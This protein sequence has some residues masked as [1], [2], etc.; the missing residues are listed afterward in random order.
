MKARALSAQRLGLGALV[1]ILLSAGAALGATCD[2]GSVCGAPFTCPT[3]FS[4]PCCTISADVQ[5]TDTCILDFVDVGIQTVTISATGALRARTT[6]ARIHAANLVVRGLLQA[7]GGDGLTYPTLQV[8]V[9]DRIEVQSGGRVDVAAED[10]AQ[11]GSVRITAGGR[12]NLSGCDVSADGGAAGAGGDIAISSTGAALQVEDCPLHADGARSG[13][14]GGSITLTA[15]AQVLINGPLTANGGVPVDGSRSVADTA[16]IAVEAAGLVQVTHSIQAHGTRSNAG[17]SIKL[18]STGDQVQISGTSGDE[19]DVDSAGSL[20]YRCVGGTHSGE[21]CDQYSP[22]CVG[23]NGECLFR[24]PQAGTIT[25]DAATA[26]TISGQT[27]VHAKGTGGGNGG[28]VS[29]L[30]RGGNALVNAPLSAAATGS[31]G[32]GGGIDVNAA[33]DITVGATLDAHGARSGI[34]GAVRLFAGGNADITGDLIATAAAGQYGD[35]GG[36]IQ[37]AAGPNGTI[38]ISGTLDA[39]AQPVTGGGAVDG[40]IVVGPACDV[41]LS[42]S[43]RTDGASGGSNIVKY[44]NSFDVRGGTMRADSDRS[45]APA[46]QAGNLIECGCPDTSPA[47][48]V[49]DGPPSCATSPLVSSGTSIIPGEQDRP[50]P[51]GPCGC[52]DG[53]QDLAATPP[54]LCDENR[55]VGG[56]SAG[57]PCTSDAGC[58]GGQCRQG[59]GSLACVGGPRSGLQCSRDDDCVLAM[60]DSGPNH[61]TPCSTSVD[62]LGDSCLRGTCSGG[63]ANGQPCSAGY[64]CFGGHCTVATC[65][66]VNGATCGASCA[67]FTCGDGVRSAGEECD[68]GNGSDGD[69]CSA[70]C[71]T[72]TP[73]WQCNDTDIC[74]ESLNLWFALPCTREPSACSPICHDGHVTPPEECDDGNNDSFDGCS[75]SCQIEA[76]YNCP[77][78]PSVCTPQPSVC[79]NHVIEPPESCDDGRRNDDSGHCKTNCTLNINGDGHV[80]TDVEQCDNGGRCVGGSSAG[81][82]C[83]VIS[84]IDRLTTQCPGGECRPGDGALECVCRDCPGH[85]GQSCTQDADCGPSREICQPVLNAQCDPNGQPAGCGNG[86]LA[87]GEDCDDGIDCSHGHQCNGAHRPCGFYCT[88]NQCGDWDVNCGP[89]GVCGT[90][91]DVEECDEGGQNGTP[92]SRCDSLCRLNCG[93]GNLDPGEQCD[94]GR[95]SNGDTN[96]CTSEC[97]FNVCGD[98]KPSSTDPPPFVTPIVYAPSAVPFHWIDISGSSTPAPL[99]DD[100]VSGPIDIGFDVLFFG[101]VFSQVY[102]SSNGFIAFDPPTSSGCCQGLPLPSSNGPGGNLV[103]GF[104]TDLY[105]P[106]GAGTSY[107]QV[108]DV[109]VIQ[110]DAPLFSSLFTGSGAAASFQ[111]Q[112]HKDSDRIEIHYLNAQPDHQTVTAGVQNGDG[113]DGFQH[114]S[115]FLGDLFQTAVAY[116]HVTIGRE[117]CDDGGV[118]AVGHTCN[119]D[120]RKCK[121]NCTRNPDYKPVSPC[122]KRLAAWYVQSPVPTVGRMV[123]QDGAAWCD[124]DHSVDGECVFSVNLCALSQAFDP[125]EPQSISRVTLTG[126][127]TTTCWGAAAAQ[128]L[129]GAVSSLDSHAS[130]NG[131]C[132]NHS[133]APRTCD[134]MHG[135]N[136]GCDARHPGDGICSP[137]VV[138]ND[139]LVASAGAGSDPVCANGS[140]SALQQIKVPAGRKLRVRSMAY[141]VTRRPATQPGAGPVDSFAL[142]HD[143]L[144]LVCH[145]AGAAPPPTWTEGP[146]PATPMVTPTPAATP[147]STATESATATPSSTDTAAATPTQT[148]TATATATQTETAAATATQTDTASATSTSTHTATATI[149]STPTLTATSSRRPTRTPGGES[150]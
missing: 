34:G 146:C 117:E 73:I 148:V 89:D 70:S 126:L 50:R 119:G 22:Q 21:L 7:P 14:P 82:A 35:S 25:V 109:F 76:G 91:D 105:P 86:Y 128:T 37:V 63:F 48:G 75:S 116:D 1:V 16:A 147:S 138:F 111:Y 53:S 69:G 104:W 47:D 84:A 99:G 129:A 29:L 122:K 87:P 79:G 62:C 77:G 71:T 58:P 132:T 51:L 121:S 103:A 88:L 80:N 26:V 42:G 68:D 120:N 150:G 43:L 24:I 137:E 102:V 85:D 6:G 110:A 56:S 140:A 59:N 124:E 49:C 130:T 107:A 133:S 113:T 28:F 10:K 40:T 57:N 19:V 65:Q 93:N 33:G 135:D 12:V 17:G 115:A 9:D 125:C 45:P 44:R 100:Q 114:Y 141:G 139:P 60:C 72:E 101:R 83:T 36:Y 96:W 15:A 136:H 112:L 54:E 81:A 38:T 92:G 78:Q 61:G 98:G 131:V 27:Q 41:L 30:A 108:G 55:C 4:P 39:R 3:G 64:S 66:P 134:F 106:A 95:L 5:L 127:D 23:G 67:P 94:L 46:L 8:A 74:D 20:A 149:T 32:F 97:R 142:D 11:R 123:C 144:L 2:A 143:R 90:G 13:D 31:Q 145:K 118:C 18:T 52:G